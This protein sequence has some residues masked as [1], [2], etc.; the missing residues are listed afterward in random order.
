MAVKVT[1]MLAR[2]AAAAVGVGT[3]WPWKTA[4]ML[5][6]ARLRKALWRPRERRGAGH[7]AVAA[8]LQ[9]VKVNLQKLSSISI[10]SAIHHF[11]LSVFFSIVF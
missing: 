3:C 5:P 2:Q 10:K 9:L 6:S 8:R 4:A 11:L 7:T 1:A